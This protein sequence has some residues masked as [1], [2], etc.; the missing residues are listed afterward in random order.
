MELDF[1]KIKAEALSILEKAKAE[2]RGL[3]QEEKTSFEERFNRLNQQKELRNLE[4]QVA[5][6]GEVDSDQLITA[7]TNSNFNKNP[8]GDLKVENKNEMSVLDAIKQFA[9]TGKNDFALISSGNSG[10]LM[11]KSVP[12][13]STIRTYS[14]AFRQGFAALGVP[15]MLASSTENVSMPALNDSANVANNDQEGATSGANADPAYSAEINLNLTEYH[16]KAIFLSKKVVSA[17]DFDFTQFIY[18]KLINRI[19]R[20]EQ[21]DWV[22]AIVAAGS[23]NVGK[24]TASTT[25]VTLS[26]LIDWDESLAASGD[27]PSF[28]LLSPTLKT[29]IR[30]LADTTNVPFF[31]VENGLTTLFGKPVFVCSALGAL[32]TG[33]TVGARVTIDSVIRDT[34]ANEIV[35]YENIPQYPGQIGWEAI[36]YSAF[37]FHSGSVKTLK[38]A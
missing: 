17:V 33:Q 21:I 25:A 23:G 36:S 35:R 1:N 29:A 11:P 10:I 30:K 14:N 13:L 7:I 31:G 20:Q 3:T 37:G 38:M 27:V 4:K 12:G 18:P 34:T 24:T 19:E 22:A 9:R 32:T 8:K 6:I 15:T 2:G 16:S 28:Y 5:S 26:E